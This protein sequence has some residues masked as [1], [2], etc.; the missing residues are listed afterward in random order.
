MLIEYLLNT[1][2]TVLGIDG[3]TLMGKACMSL[4]LECLKHACVH[5][6]TVESESKAVVLAWRLSPP[7]WWSLDLG[8]TV[9]MHLWPCVALVYNSSTLWQLEVVTAVD[10]GAFPVLFH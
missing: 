6:S 9:N 5:R 4:F 1:P 2:G 10:Q 8:C 3:S 7:L